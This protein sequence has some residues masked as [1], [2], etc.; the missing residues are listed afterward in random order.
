MSKQILTE[1]QRETLG[2]IKKFI[3]K[4]ELP[5]TVREVGRAFGIKSSSAFHLLARLERKGYIKR[6]TLGARS[7]KVLDPEV[8]PE[9]SNN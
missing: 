2:W 3:R 5:P 6:G 1:R 7:L 4:H 9:S 8:R